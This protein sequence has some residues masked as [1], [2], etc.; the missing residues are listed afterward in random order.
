MVN[1]DPFIT[2]LCK[3]YGNI[4]NKRIIFFSNLIFFT[5]ARLL[6]REAYNGSAIYL[7]LQLAAQVSLLLNFLLKT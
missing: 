2:F 6:S 1:L 4:K 3:G 7:H 5:V